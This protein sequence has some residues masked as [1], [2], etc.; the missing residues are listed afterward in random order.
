MFNYTAKYVN[1]ENNIINKHEMLNLDAYIHITSPIRRLV[2]LLN[3]I[4]FQKNHAMFESRNATHFYYKHVNNIDNI[5]IF[6]NKAKKMQNECGLLHIFLNNELQLTQGYIFNKSVINKDKDKEK[7]KD[8]EKMFNYT[9][10]LPE[11]K[12]ISKIKT[13]IEYDNYEKKMFKL[14]LFNNEAKFK[15]KIRLAI[16]NE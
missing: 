16:E 14:C 9:V 4:Q 1:K 6:M 10:Y 7:E 2:D 12:L 13:M 8:K 3:I 15:K 5:N 11:F